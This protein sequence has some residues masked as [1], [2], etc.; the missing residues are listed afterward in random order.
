MTFINYIWVRNVVLRTLLSENKYALP[1][2]GY[3]KPICSL[4]NN[5]SEEIPRI[6]NIMIGF[7]SFYTRFR[8]KRCI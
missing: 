7:G 2:E 6:N 4:K 1:G 5:Q 3:F 8:M